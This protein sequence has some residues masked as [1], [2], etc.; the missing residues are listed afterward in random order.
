MRHPSY[1]DKMNW[2]TDVVIPILLGLVSAFGATWYSNKR[3]T[4]R[5]KREANDRV[6]DAIRSYIRALRE[7]SDFLEARA[8]SYGG[9]DPSSG[10]INHGGETAVR[11]AFD[12]AAPHF[13][14]LDVREEDGKPL[15]NEFPDYGNAPMD[16]SEN[17]YK[18]AN[19]I[20]I[21]LDR[22]LTS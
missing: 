14:R 11:E 1:L 5:L 15:R 19:Q 17:F 2:I 4:E 10:V 12:A 6:A 18:R 13:H 20:Q 3:S 22:G 21:V 9:H 16:G 8:Q 7:T